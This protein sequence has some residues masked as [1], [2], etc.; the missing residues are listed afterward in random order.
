M[1][2]IYVTSCNLLKLLF[3]YSLNWSVTEVNNMNQT[4]ECTI[5]QL[6][7]PLH[8]LPFYLSFLPFYSILSKPESSVATSVSSV[9]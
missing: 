3:Y 8:S 6:S 5:L 9:T 4:K 2:V 7:F 1:E